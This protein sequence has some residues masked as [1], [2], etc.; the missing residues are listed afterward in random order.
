MDDSNPAESAPWDEA[1]YQQ[2]QARAEGSNLDPVTLLATDYL[3]HFNEIVML[4]EMV[5][6]MPEILDDAKE[7]QPKTY[8]DHFRSSTIADRELAVDAYPCVPPKYK[9]PFEETVGLINALIA[10]TV[11]RL[12]AEVATGEME[13]VRESATSLSRNI[14]RLM[15]FASAIMHGTTKTLAQSDIDQM[16]DV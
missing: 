16:M 7:W 4:L 11:E 13:R 2:M 9:Q 15:D 12:D 5:P 8:V 1:R 14:Q 3:N 6:D 10:S